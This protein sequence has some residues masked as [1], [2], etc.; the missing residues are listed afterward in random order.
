MLVYICDGLEESDLGPGGECDD[1]SDAINDCLGELL[2][3][4][5]AVGGSVSGIM[6]GLT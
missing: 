1:Q 3:A 5:W 2:I 6:F 4:A